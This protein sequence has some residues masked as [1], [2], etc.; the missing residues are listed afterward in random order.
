MIGVGDS[1]TAYASSQS[2]LVG[3]NTAGASMEANYPSYA[4]NGSGGYDI[5]FR[6]LFGA[7]EAN[8][9]WQEWGVFCDNSI[10]GGKM[11]NRKVESLGTK[12]N[13]QSWQITAT[14]S[15]TIA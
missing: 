2:A 4:N 10:T 8:F 1:T 5:A 9:A 7:S 15:F 13:T 14:L 3:S 12:P 6:A 11:V